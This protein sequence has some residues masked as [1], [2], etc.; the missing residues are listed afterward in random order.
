MLHVCV[1]AQFACTCILHCVWCCVRPRRNISLSFLGAGATGAHAVVRLVSRPSPCRL[2]RA[3]PILPQADESGDRHL[4]L[5]S[6]LL[7]WPGLV[8]PC[9]SVPSAFL[10]PPLVSPV[11][12]PFST[13]KCFASCTFSSALHLDSSAAIFCTFGTPRA[14]PNPRLISVSFGRHPPAI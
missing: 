1:H 6:I 11:S 14:S 4:H 8:R 12:S 9:L 10:L 7:F 2:C 3:C 13:F 5:P